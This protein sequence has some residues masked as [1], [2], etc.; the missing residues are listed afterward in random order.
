MTS[1]FYPRKT[2]LIV[3]VIALLAIALVVVPV[4]A[5]KNPA[6]VYC[7][8]MGY[9]S[10][11]EK[12][13]GGNDVAMCILPNGKAV[14]AWNFLKGTTAAEYSYCAKSGFVQKTV[15]NRAVCGL[16]AID[17]CAVCVQPDGRETEVTNLMGLNF[18][19]SVCGDGTC[20]LP[21]N[22]LTCHK[23]CPSSAYDGLCERSLDGKCDPDCS[24]L[25][26]D[27]DCSATSLIIY[28]LFV[29]VI[30]VIIALVVRHILKRRQQAP[31]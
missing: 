20:G 19:E 16:F 13:A 5:L 4:S 26:S 15:K 27:P 30:L 18:A 2:L 22:S 1:V 10:Y 12:D 24:G 3:G 25:L 31:K 14:D 7:L 9:Q 11:T 8:A 29:L 28:I 17:T 23:D 21:E 6:A